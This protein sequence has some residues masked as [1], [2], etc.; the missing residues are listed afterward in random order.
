MVELSDI[1]ELPNGLA[2]LVEGQ[3]YRKEGAYLVARR[4]TD[5]YYQA[6]LI[7]DEGAEPDL[8]DE[9]TKF[10]VE[11]MPSIRQACLEASVL[12]WYREGDV[13]FAIDL[14]ALALGLPDPNEIP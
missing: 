9:L 12:R 6:M 2:F 14:E 13:G 4:A 8:S 11:A 1:L 10:W 5:M 3:Q 7:P